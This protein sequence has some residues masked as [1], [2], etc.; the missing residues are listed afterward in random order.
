MATSKKLLLMVCILLVSAG[1]IAAAGSRD[2]APGINPY[3]RYDGLTIDVQNLSASIL[4][5]F[6]KIN[7]EE[8]DYFIV[9]FND[10]IK[11]GWRAELEQKGATILWYIPDNAYLVKMNKAQANALSGNSSIYW[12]SVQQPYF[13]LS[14]EIRNLLN[15]KDISQAVTENGKIKLAVTLYA[16][17][18][19]TNLKSSL[20]SAGLGSIISEVTNPHN[21]RI[22]VNVY[23]NDFYKA[24]HLL[25]AMKEVEGI[26]QQHKFVLLNDAARWV[27]QRFVN[28]SYP[29]YA[30]NLRGQNQVGG[31]SDTGI[32]YDM[33][34]FRDTTL[35]A[36]PFDNTPPFGDV[37]EN[38]NMRKMII[39]YSMDA[40]T[41]AGTGTP[42]DDHGHGTHTGGSFI[43]D[44]FATAC[45]TGNGD[46]G[47]GMALCAKV[48]VQDMG[49]SLNFINIPCGTVYDV[50]NIAYLDGARVHS[51]S[52]GWGCD[53]CPCSGNMYGADARDVD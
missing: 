43:G 48:V 37:A 23:P 41:C 40:T 8:T 9:K 3:I 11:A 15:Q 53:A 39:Y 46:A 20:A 14:Q 50:F 2:K 17:E 49:G 47:D 18:T 35:G 26:E 22:W 27:H 5:G 33:C 45:G 6:D 38:N 25:A 29:L 21:T 32:D 12:I 31:I 52:W 42:G 34:Y 36:P 51:N 13:K 16:S 28:G 44:N 4:P 7:A 19:T 30:N 1:I 10:V 24:V